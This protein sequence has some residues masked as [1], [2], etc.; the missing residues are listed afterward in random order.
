MMKRSTHSFA[1]LLSGSLA[2]LL[3]TPAGLSQDR[4]R[5][6][7]GPIVLNPD[8]VPAFADPPAGFD[9]RRKNIPHGRL[10]MITY[11]S[12]SVGTTRRMQVYTP[13]GY[14]KDKKYPVLYLLHG[15]GGDETEWQRFATPNVLLDNLIADGKAVPMIVVMPNGRAQK[16]DRA[17]GNVFRSAPA[18][19]AF[20]KDL[21]KDVIP[22]I[23]SRYSVRADREHRALAGLSMGGGQSLNFG[24]GHL[25][26]FAWIGAFSA[27]P[28]TK[29]AKQLMPDPAAA[30]AKLKLLFLSC[31][32]KDGLIRISQGVHAYL[33]ENNVPHIW[34]VDGNAHDPTH[35]KNSLYHFVQR[36]FR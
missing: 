32:K 4:R 9:A 16:N 24:L 22:A 8:D 13:P 35:W 3:L 20:E 12:N 17:E 15:I 14:S 28:N 31:G 27:A 34:H 23:E 19:A 10:E 29:P 30:K 1:A 11:D 25:D 36:I 33:K 21:L 2:L 18:F 6:P 5:G 26:T 7:G